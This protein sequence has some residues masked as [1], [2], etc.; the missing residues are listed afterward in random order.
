[1]FSPPKFNV[2]GKQYLVATYGTDYLF[3]GNQNLL[4]GAPFRPAKPGD[5]LYLYGVG[6]GD[7]TANIP[8]GVIPTVLTQLIAQVQF[9]FGPALVTPYYAGLYPNY[10]GLYLFGLVV[11]D[12]PDGD[13]LI[14]VRVNGQPLA[15]TFYLTV[16][17]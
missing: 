13:H 15:Q 8:S 2:G 16:K 7:V 5:I 12:V 14:T 6:F 11:P 1:M 4:P 10:L 3:V 9:Q 17:R